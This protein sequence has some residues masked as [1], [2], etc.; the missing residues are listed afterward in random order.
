METP[1]ATADYQQDSCEIWSSVQHPKRI[2]TRTGKVVG[3]EVEQFKLHNFP[4][5][6]SFG[7]RFYDDFITETVFLSKKAAQPIKL[8]WSRE[9]EIQTSGYHGYQEETHT[10]ALDEANNILGWKQRTS[11]AAR[12]D[13]LNWGSPIHVYYN[14]H[15]F[16]DLIGIQAQLPVMAWRSVSA[17][18]NALGLECFIDE[19]AH[20][21]KK[22]PLQL[23]LDFMNNYES[24]NKFAEAYYE[25]IDKYVVETLMPRAKRV[26]EKIQSLPAWTEPLALGHGR[27][28][29]GESFGAT[30]AGQVAEVSVNNGKLIIHKITCVVDCGRVINPHQATGQIEGGIIWGLSALKQNITVENGSVR[31]SNF[32]DYPVLRMDQM[33]EIEVIFIESEEA[34]V[35]VGEP[36]VPPVAPAVLNAIFAATGK[37]IREL[38]IREV[39][40]I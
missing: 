31:Q 25:R 37:R 33:P 3:L 38:P 5:G 39:D 18:Q 9:D 30:Y 40:L 20:E 28:V 26:Y 19:L 23:R 10:V 2:L 8:V 6:G 24:P 7:R 32:H 21:I 1:S 15:R 14:K 4:C 27:G 17:H 12:G 35:G 29:A 16:Y 11:R 34:P 36:G 22:D 13:E